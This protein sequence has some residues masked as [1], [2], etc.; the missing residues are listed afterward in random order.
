MVVFESCIDVVI[1]TLRQRCGFNVDTAL[2]CG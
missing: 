1:S 2:K